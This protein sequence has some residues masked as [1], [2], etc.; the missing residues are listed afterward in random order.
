VP[1]LELTPGQ[2][3]TLSVVTPEPQIRV[4]GPIKRGLGGMLAVVKDINFSTN[5]LGGN[6][7]GVLG[8]VASPV[9]LTLMVDLLDDLNLAIGTAKAA[10]VG[11]VVV[12]AGIV[13]S[14]IK[15]ELDL[16]QHEVIGLI[17]RGVG[18]QDNLLERVVFAGWFM[19]VGKPFDGEGRP[20]KGMRDDEI[21]EK[22]T[23]LLPYLVLL[24]YKTLLN[25]TPH[26]FLLF[27]HPHSLSSNP[28][29]QT[30]IFCNSKQKKDKE[31]GKLDK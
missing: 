16:G 23:I 13:L 20:L 11:A 17:L 7:E 4:T 1:L 25:L 22:R 19:A 9:N 21:I 15:R 14:I 26:L 3:I 10:D 24:V 27:P 31:K 5:C 29:N 28:N 30:S 6:D 2:A 12:M 18:A 8:H